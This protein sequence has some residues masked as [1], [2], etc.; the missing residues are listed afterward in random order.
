MSGKKRAIITGIEAYLPE[1][2]LDNHM[3]SEMVDTT[4]EW[5]MTRIGVREKNP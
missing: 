5:I 2:I 3:L 4:D 1:Y